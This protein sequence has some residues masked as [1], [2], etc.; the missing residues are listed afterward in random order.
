MLLSLKKTNQLI[1]SLIKQKE[2]Y[3]EVLLAY[4][5]FLEFQDPFLEQAVVRAP[6][7]THEDA[8]RLVL[9]GKSLLKTPGAELD[10]EWAADYAGKLAAYFAEKKPDVWQDFAD[11]V[12]HGKMPVK[13]AQRAFIEDDLEHIEKILPPSTIALAP[14]LSFLQLSLK[15]QLF[16][17]ADTAKGSRQK[18]AWT[19]GYC[20]VC[21]AFPAFSS[22]GGPLAPWVLHCPNC[23]RA[24]RYPFGRC[25]FCENAEEGSV[26]LFE[27]ENTGLGM[28]A[29]PKC[30]G[31]IKFVDRSVERT[32][33]PFPLA[34]L[35]TLDID[36]LAQEKGCAK[37][38]LGVF[39]V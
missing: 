35:I 31:Y 37:L 38:S 1:D 33:P 9:K 3:R 14:F 19:R 28:F 36:V 21:G 2:P 11:R 4:R 30:T 32:F 27:I 17:F 6:E 23:E 25:P 7:V 34:E 39:G 22:K 29:C 24:Y 12:L 18:D 16:K 5:D 26:K 10:P 15:P 20:P 8:H 13:E